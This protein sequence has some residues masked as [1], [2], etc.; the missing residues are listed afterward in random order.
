MGDGKPYGK[1]IVLS[2][3]HRVVPPAGKIL[4]KFFSKFLYVRDFPGKIQGYTSA[5]LR[6][7]KT[8]SRYLKKFPRPIIF[9]Y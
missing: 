2:F 7:R 3:Y 6:S 9:Y 4:G 1:M 8:Y 5:V